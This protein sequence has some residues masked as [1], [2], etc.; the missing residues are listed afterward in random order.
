MKAKP[1]KPLFYLLSLLAA[2]VVQLLGAYLI[3]RFF[4][5]ETD[6]ALLS[7]TIGFYET[8][9]P[10]FVVLT[11][12]VWLVFLGLTVFAFWSGW[13]RRPLSGSLLV[14]G[15]VAALFAV[16]F[17]SLVMTASLQR[18]MPVFTPQLAALFKVNH[19]TVSGVLAVLTG[20]LSIFLVL[21]VVMKQGAASW[22]GKHKRLFGALLSLPAAAAVLA[23]EELCYFLLRR[24]ELLTLRKYF[25]IVASLIVIILF[26]IAGWLLARRQEK[27][28]SSESGRKL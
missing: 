18:G 16:T 15:C 3:V 22:K 5:S 13:Y 4:T 10:A 20:L 2:A 27:K 26:S 6:T 9:P 21:A 14:L 12:L 17:F 7:R 1:L 19:D 24:A 8:L 23:L 28:N 25:D 11:A